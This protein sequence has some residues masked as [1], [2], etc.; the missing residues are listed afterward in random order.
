MARL[1][2]GMGNVDSPNHTQ[3]D[4]LE[5]DLETL[6]LFAQFTVLRVICT[7]MLVLRLPP[8][9]DEYDRDTW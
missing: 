4:C 6:K 7:P 5:S 9:G 1:V 2:E 3:K 8:L